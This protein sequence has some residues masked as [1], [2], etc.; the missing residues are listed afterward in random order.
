MEDKNKAIRTSLKVI[1]WVM[2]IL[3]LFALYISLRTDRFSVQYAVAALVL[4][5]LALGSNFLGKK[6]RK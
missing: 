4:W 2:I 6:Y 5:L 1:T 3:S